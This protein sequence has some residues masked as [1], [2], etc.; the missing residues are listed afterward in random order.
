MLN[1]RRAERHVQADTTRVELALMARDRV[2]ATRFMP[3]EWGGMRWRLAGMGEIGG[4]KVAQ[5]AGR[6][7]S[8][9]GPTPKKVWDQSGTN[10][11]PA[12]TLLLSHRPVSPNS[13]L[14]RMY[15]TRLARLASASASASA[16]A[17]QTRS[18]SLWSIPSARPTLA[19][20]PSLT[21]QSS[22]STL[23]SPALGRAGY[24]TE[25]GEDG[26][27]VKAGPPEP[28]P[29]LFECT[30]QDKARLTRMRNVGIS[31]HIDVSNPLH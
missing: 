2:E 3:D 11:R 22:P 12:P 9:L 24:A 16:S 20:A 6:A 29:P 19:L 1:A 15:R 28:L 13:T 30:A 27:L 10:H 23:A 7:M 5:P 18:L 25:V 14:S 21:R 26:E 31:A 4:G 8:E 17:R